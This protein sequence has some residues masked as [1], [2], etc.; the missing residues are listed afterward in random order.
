MERRNTIVS[1]Y[2]TYTVLP[3]TRTLPSDVT[4][5]IYLSLRGRTFIGARIIIG[6]AEIKRE[7]LLKQTEGGMEGKYIYVLESGRVYNDSM[8]SR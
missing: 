5:T 8:I 4:D 6:T 3:L 7:E 1:N 2:M